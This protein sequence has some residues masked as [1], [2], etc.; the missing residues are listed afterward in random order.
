[1]LNTPGYHYMRRGNDSLDHRYHENYLEMQKRIFGEF[2]AY[3]CDSVPGGKVPEKL[4]ALCFNAMVT[5]MDN[6]YV[7]RK[8]MGKKQYRNG[9][10]EGVRNPALKSM[11]DQMEGTAKIIYLLRYFFLSHGFFILDY[12]LRQTAKKILGMC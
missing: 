1:M 5:V 11:V 12:Y 10:K 9:M 3:Y 4:L 2:F 6:L 8:Q 7:N